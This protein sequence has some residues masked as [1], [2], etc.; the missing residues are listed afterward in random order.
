LP[1]QNLNI[2]TRGE[3]WA[4]ETAS[5]QK[6]RQKKYRISRSHAR[7]Y[8][9]FSWD[10]VARKNNVAFGVNAPLEEAIGV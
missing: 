5:P 8:V 4:A 7:L 6:R 3:N 1:P 9:D 10:S 2:S